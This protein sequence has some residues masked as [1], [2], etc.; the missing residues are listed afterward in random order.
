MEQRQDWHHHADRVLHAIE[1]QRINP[2]LI[3]RS[4][5]RCIEEYALDP[6]Q[7]RPARIVT[8]QT[9]REH[10]QAADQF[11]EVARGCVEQ[12]YSQISA[13]GYVL[14]LSDARGV[15]VQFWG[16]ERR[17]PRLRKVGLYLGADWSERYAGTCAVGTCI[18][19]QQALTCHHHQHFDS[20]HI[21]LSC[22]AAPIFDPQGELIAVLDISALDTAADRASQNFALHLT[23]MYA[24]MIEDAYFLRLYRSQLVLRMDAS[25]ELARV[26]G[27]ILFALSDQGQLLAANS[28]GR[29]LLQQQRL[30]LNRSY[31]IELLAAQWH[32]LLE[33]PAAPDQ[34][35]AFH[36]FNSHL[37]YASLL[38]PEVRRA[39]QPSEIQHSSQLAQLCDDDPQMRKTLDV[40][41]KLLK[42]DVNIL[43]LGETGTGKEVFAQ[44]FHADSAR[45]KA[46]FIALNCA[47]IPESL[48]E[49]E[50]FGYSAGTFTGGRAKGAVGLIQ[51]AQGG[52]LF[53][54]EIG[55]MP[56]TLQTRLLRVLA[57]GEITP[58]GS[59]KPIKV[60]CRI[61]AA[62]HCDLQTWVEQGK[63]RAD[64]Y[65]RLNGALLRLPPLRERADKG[66]IIERV[67][68]RLQQGQATR[69]TLRAD[70]KSALLGYHWPG[71][72]RQLYNALAFAEATCS[73]GVIT[74][75]DLP[76]ECLLCHG[77]R[78]PQQAQHSR[79]ESDTVLGTDSH[80]ARLLAQAMQQ[81]AGNISAVARSLNIS[82]P[83]V[84]RRLRKYRD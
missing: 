15:T 72:I 37:L 81:H 83:T 63:F 66:Y 19:D 45:A 75:A 20:T 30:Q 39:A 2:D 5:Q 14:L 41:A 17:D 78:E 23:Q 36:T 46:P 49:S 29:Q 42:R 74:A 6:A 77:L 84:Y 13:L 80:E 58:L 52:T 25:R 79:K 26:S 64:L 40:A 4:W 3:T 43:L 32:E 68:A 59:A 70:A 82:R 53:L 1:Q 73:D 62:T 48:I 54:D 7:G 11:L 67:L 24:R 57:E 21:H 69:V 31:I 35:R 61:I 8:Q 65:Y 44:A 12:L 33:L 18:T 27:A 22:T 55:D 9:L 71:N 16:S 28:A 38:L 60:D 34:V 10:Q 76:E 51:Q 47:A 56:L 50:L